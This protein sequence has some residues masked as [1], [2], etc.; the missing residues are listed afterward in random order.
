MVLVMETIKLERRRGGG[1]GG[2]FVEE[3]RNKIVEEEE[4]GMY[5]NN[6]IQKPT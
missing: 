3:E 1:G 5:I 6:R 2:E 4:V